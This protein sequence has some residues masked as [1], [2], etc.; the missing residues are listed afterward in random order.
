MTKL[1]KNCLIISI[2]FRF[3]TYFYETSLSRNHGF[4]P[5]DL[6]KFPLQGGDKIQGRQSA[7]WKGS[8]PTAPTYIFSCIRSCVCHCIFGYIIHLSPARIYVHMYASFS[9]NPCALCLRQ[10]CPILL[11][12]DSYKTTKLWR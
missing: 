2:I 1:N 12:L 8:G 7:P 11:L 6:F 5:L 9:I 10:V 4:V 3:I